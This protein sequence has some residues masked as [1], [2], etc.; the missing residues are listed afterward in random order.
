MARSS[1]PGEPLG[2][3]AV[4]SFRPLAG[5]LRRHA[6]PVSELGGPVR[7]MTTKAR[8]ENRHRFLVEK[9]S[10]AVR[11]SGRPSTPIA[12]PQEKQV[13]QRG[14]LRRVCPWSGHRAARRLSGNASALKI[15]FGNSRD[16][17]PRSMRQRVGAPGWV[18][19]NRLPRAR[20]RAT[21]RATRPDSQS[22]PQGTSAWRNRGEA[23]YQSTNRILDA[24]TERRAH[25]TGCG[26]ASVRSGRS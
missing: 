3:H 26:R 17:R 25:R 24:A 16:A 9:L 5:P 10:D 1:H 18:T 20:K 4:S 6:D 22:V 15:A 19:I 2:N 14:W 7:R 13:R 8:D 23:G 12:T 11:E 21:A